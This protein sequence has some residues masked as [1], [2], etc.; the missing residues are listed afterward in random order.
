MADRHHAVW[1][2]ACAGVWGRPELCAPSAEHPVHPEGHPV[3]AAVYCNVL[4][5]NMVQSK[6]PRSM[7]CEKKLGFAVP[8]S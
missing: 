8:E 2:G 5:C 7:L 4:G 6:E 3:G 1:V